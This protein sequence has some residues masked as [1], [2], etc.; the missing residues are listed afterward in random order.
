MASIKIL[1]K[2]NKTLSDGRHPI[3][4]RII[5]D[6]KTKF[7]FT[8]KHSLK[9]HW[10]ENM[11]LPNKKHPLFKE[12]VI[13]LKKRLLDAET[14]LLGL[15]KDNQYFTAD[16]V[17][18][19]LKKSPKA[20]NVFHFYDRIIAELDSIGKLGSK[21]MY[22]SGRS[23]VLKFVN[24]NVNLQF[25]AIDVSFLIR[26]EKYMYANGL[27][28]SSIYTYIDNLKALYNRAIKEKVVKQDMSPFTNYEMITPNTLP[29]HRAMGKENIEMMFKYKAEEGTK[30]YDALMCFTFSYYCWGI[31][32]VDIAKLKWKNIQDNRLIYVRTK[33]G[34]LYNIP[35]LQPA[36]DILEHYKKNNANTQK[37]TIYSQ[38]L[39]RKNT[40]RFIPLPCVPSILLSIPTTH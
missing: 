11:G 37:K 30:E 22:V 5:K 7:I 29:A 13:Y 27:Q 26:Y 12:L 33:T 34:R 24:A 4:I 20:N 21:N 39:I 25:S 31:N 15:E 8:G 18:Q 23:S 2:T 10:D 16:T 40:K 36:K 38:Y 6:R 35:L 19:N 14:E 32:M 17:K 9:E 1:L 3:A 28:P